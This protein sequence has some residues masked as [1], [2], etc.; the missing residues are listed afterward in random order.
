MIFV[1]DHSTDQSKLKAEKLAQIDSRITVYANP[2]G[3]KGANAARNLGLSKTDADFV[4]FLDSDD[5]MAPHCLEN[6]LADFEE[7]PECALI[8]YPTGLFHDVL[9]DSEVICN[10]PSSKS[11]LERFLERD[12]V[13]LISGPIWRRQTLIDLDG[14][15]LNLHSQQDFDL[16]VRALIK[17]YTYKY[18]HREPDVFYRRNIDSVPRQQSQSVEHFRHRFNMQLKHHQLLLESGKLND[19]TARLLAKSILDLAQMMRWHIAEL[20][21]KALQEAE[22]M[23][24][25]CRDLNLINQKDFRT[26]LKYIRFKHQMIYNRLPAL[27]R[28]LEARYRK[29]LDGLIHYPSNTYCKVTL[30]DYDR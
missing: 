25:T 24:A 3:A 13:W 11:D 26:G 17:S 23:W 18:F 7:N 5:L 21:K 8:I 10:I 19:S 12:I 6:R 28:K 2:T 29:K 27:R 16:H 30:G 9:G 4:I 1:D 20:G 14:F 15:D 22:E